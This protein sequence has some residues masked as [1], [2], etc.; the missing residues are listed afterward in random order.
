MKL[1][2]LAGCIIK[3]DEERI[4][5]LHRNTT[6]RTQWEIPGG[7]IDDGESPEQTAVRELEEELGVQV[8]IA[9][10]LGGK[11]FQEDGYTMKYTWFRAVV[12]AGEP[13][14]ME[15]STHDDVRYFAVGDL[16]ELRDEL[17][18]NTV[19]FLDEYTSGRIS[20]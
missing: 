16:E 6:K 17:S 10:E 2:H 15:P 8:K 4:L 13:T 14:V 11:S 18:P 12:L 1:L 20:L 5:L 3:D 7:K 19:N 9:G